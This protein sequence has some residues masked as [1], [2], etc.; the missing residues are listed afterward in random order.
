MDDVLIAVRT[1]LRRPDRTGIT[2]AADRVALFT[3]SLRTP[4]LT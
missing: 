2:A 4:A 3:D 1:L